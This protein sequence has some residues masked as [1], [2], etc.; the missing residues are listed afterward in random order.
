VVSREQRLRKL[1][2]EQGVPVLPLPS[3]G[4]AG[5]LVAKSINNIISCSCFLNGA[6]KSP[7]PAHPKSPE[8]RHAQ[9]LPGLQPMQDL[10]TIGA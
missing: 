1:L 7:S 3:A 9:E 5:I 10:H 4:D 8:V 2:R 6:H